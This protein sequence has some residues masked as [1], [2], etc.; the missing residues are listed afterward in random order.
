M[1]WL[2][3]YVQQDDWLLKIGELQVKW[4]R[5]SLNARSRGNTQMPGKE[6]AD[7]TK[8]ELDNHHVE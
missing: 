8:S 2:D 3:S 5:A 7:T 4:E 1:D 6:N